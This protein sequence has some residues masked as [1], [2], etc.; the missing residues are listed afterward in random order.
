MVE[1][2]S[3]DFGFWVDPDHK[4]TLLDSAARAILRCST[5]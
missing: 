1:Q 3:I 2:E 4:D 5:L